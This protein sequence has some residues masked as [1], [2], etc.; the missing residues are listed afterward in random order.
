MFEVPATVKGLVD[1]VP[2]TAMGRFQ[3]EAAAVDPGTG[4][5]YETEDSFDSKGLFYRFLPNDR[6]NP[7]K[8]GR[9]QALGFR[10][11]P[12]GGDA[13]NMKGSEPTWRVGETRDGADS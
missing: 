1:P 11:A 2:L 9:L 5:I 13:R 12:E 6:R 8:G 4:V 7:A 10:N 3:H